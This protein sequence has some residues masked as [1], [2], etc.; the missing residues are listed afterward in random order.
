LSSIAGDSDLVKPTADPAFIF[1]HLHSFGDVKESAIRTVKRNLASYSVEGDVLFSEA[2]IV[3]SVEVER[4]SWQRAHTRMLHDVDLEEEGPECC[5]SR[6]DD[7][8]EDF[9]R[10][11]SFRDDDD[12]S[13]QEDPHFHNLCNSNGNAESDDEDTQILSIDS[14]LGG[15]EA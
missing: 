5:D 7:W 12:D 6:F 2:Y 13:T 3:R 11:P 10:R 4:E 8:E 15:E 14:P 1:G 9:H